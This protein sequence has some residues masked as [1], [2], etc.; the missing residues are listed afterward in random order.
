MG[1]IIRPTYPRE[2]SIGILLLIGVIACFLS[3]Q[4]FD[5]PIHALNKNKNVYFGMFLVSIAVINMVLILWEQILFPIRVKEVDGG[6]VFRNHSTKLITQVLIYSTI[7]AIFVFIYLNYDIKPIR[8][9]IWAAVCII[10]PVIEKIVSGINNYNDFLKLTNETIEY[11]NNEKEGAF[12]IGD[13]QSLAILQDDRKI[14]EKL[15]LTFTNK[16]SVTIDLDEMELD[17]FYDSIN[18][19]IKAHYIHLLDQS[20]K[21]NVEPSLA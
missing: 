5:V 17:A 13:I 1:K 9:G 14:I 21:V 12:K 20:K 11:K 7:P 6:M 16:D 18:S 8:F 15:Q 3:H 4:I 2:F 19:Y 10:P